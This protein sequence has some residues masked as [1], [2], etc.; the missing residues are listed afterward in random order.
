[1]SNNVFRL[2]PN[3]RYIDLR[4]IQYG[5]EQCTPI[6]L[7]VLLQETIF[8]SITFYLERDVSLLRILMAIQSSILSLLAWDF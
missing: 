3:E 8:Y 1:M 6:I 7:M 2:F 4:L 5:K